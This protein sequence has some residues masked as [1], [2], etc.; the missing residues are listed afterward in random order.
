MSAQWKALPRRLQH[1]L[2]T[3]IDHWPTFYLPLAR[4]QSHGDCFFSVVSA[5]SEVVI[6]GFPRS[7][8][9]FAFLAFR[10]AQEREIEIAHHTHAP[11]Q[12]KAAVRMGLPVLLI[13]R[14]PLDALSSLLV[15][16]PFLKASRALQYYF[17]FHNSVVQFSSKIFIADFEQIICDF[18]RVTQ[19]LNAYYGTRFIEFTHSDTNVARCF[20]CAEEWDK[21]YYHN[22]SVDEGTVAR[23]SRH[24]THLLKEA[25]KRLTDRRL[26]NLHLRAQQVYDILRDQSGG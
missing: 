24:R 15:Q 22:A 7:G 21:G 10:M 25:R 16:A 5:K 4:L 14:T 12:I 1:F 20:Q 26:S 13:V 18:G 17:D 3:E 8:N 23:P 19:S 2:G 9:T 11:A 6:E